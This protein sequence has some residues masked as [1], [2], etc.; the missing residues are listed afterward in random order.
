MR[1]RSCTYDAVFRDPATVTSGLPLFDPPSAFDRD[2][3]AERLQHLAAENIFIGGS[4]WK[5][6]GWMGQIYSRERYLTRGRF[7]KKRFEQE[8]LAEYAETFPMVCGDFSFYQFPPPEFW[9]K[10]FACAPEKLRFG[11]KVP[12]EITVKRFPTQ[13]RYGPRAGLDNP[14]YLDVNMLDA[15]FLE[16]LRPYAAR[17]AVLI[18]EFGTFSKASY[19]EPEG[20]L[21]DLDRFLT[22]LPRGEFRYSVEVRNQEFLRDDYF[23]L[24]RRHGVAHVFN[25]W[26]RMPPIPAQIQIPEAFTTD[27]IVARALLRTGRPY[28]RAVEEFSPYA[29]IR[30]PNPETREALR[31]L[32]DRAKNRRI[33]AYLFVNNRLEG[34]APLTIQAVLEDDTMDDR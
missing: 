1:L 34:S 33:P 6:D 30:D 13:Q 2:A 9:Q 4:S 18:F 3:V 31:D 7:S 19:P 16:A 24:L 15:M 8:C 26:T 11:F 21:E 17:I 23:A 28:E 29:E 32:I 5:Y 12:E 20:F 22:A 10:L 14:T 27:F 25:A